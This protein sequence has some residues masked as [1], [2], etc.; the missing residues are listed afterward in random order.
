MHSGVRHCA[1]NGLSLLAAIQSI[2]LLR[3]VPGGG[4]IIEYP[5]SGFDRALKVGNIKRLREERIG[6][7]A[8]R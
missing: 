6:T 2:F 8:P 3:C 5:G 4:D 1:G 7:A